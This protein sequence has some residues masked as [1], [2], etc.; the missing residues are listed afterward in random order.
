VS[1]NWRAVGLAVIARH[2]IGCRANSRTMGSKRVSGVDDVA[3]NASRSTRHVIGC[4]VTQGTRVQKRVDDG[5]R[6]KCACSH[7]EGGDRYEDHLSPEVNNHE[8]VEPQL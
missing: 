3:G 7:Q 4:R 8:E 2:V 5:A 1:M 6:A